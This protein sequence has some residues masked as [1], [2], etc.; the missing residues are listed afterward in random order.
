FEHA[1]KHQ[2]ARDAGKDRGEVGGLETE[3]DGGEARRVGVL[4]QGGGKLL[5]VGDDPA[6]QGEEAGDLRCCVR[7]GRS[8]LG[9][10]VGRGGLGGHERIKNTICGPM[11]RKIFFGWLRPVAGELRRGVSRRGI[12]REAPRV[13][14]TVK[15]ASKFL[16]QS[17]TEFA[18][19]SRRDR[20]EITEN[21]TSYRPPYFLKSP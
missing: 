1:R 9:G 2:A 4:L 19:R 12:Q 17:F 16:T 7:A 8:R 21:T 6:D 18:Q 3:G 13:P 10:G 15:Q 11:S 14:T 5:A 20:A